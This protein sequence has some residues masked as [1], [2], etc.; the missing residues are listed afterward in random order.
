MSS[1]SGSL[2]DNWILIFDSA[3]N[4]SGCIVLVK[5]EVY[6]TKSV[7]TQRGSELE[8]ESAPSVIAFSDSHGNSS[9]ILLSNSTSMVPRWL[10]TI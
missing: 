6:K 9:L 8:K 2:E 4:L 3:S 10:I 7:F 1:V 5:V